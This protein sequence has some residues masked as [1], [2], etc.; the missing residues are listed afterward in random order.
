MLIF[1]PYIYVRA[2]GSHTCTY[3]GAIFGSMNEKHT[4]YLI[5]KM[6]WLPQRLGT[7]KPSPATPGPIEEVASGH[8]P[9][10]SHGWLAL[11]PAAPA[12]HPSSPGH[13]ESSVPLCFLA[14]A[15]LRISLAQPKDV[16]IFNDCSKTNWVHGP[17]VLE[18]A[19]YQLN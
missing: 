8:L 7:P 11:S 3:S 4:C 10:I 1:G 2:C 18:H 5:F 13:G 15:S 19:D 16:A 9:K 6:T 14:C 17:L 12:S